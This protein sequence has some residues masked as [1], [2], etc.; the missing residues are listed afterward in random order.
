MNIRFGHQCVHGMQVPPRLRDKIESLKCTNVVSHATCV[1][2]R[3]SQHARIYGSTPT[4]H[5]QNSNVKTALS[6][7]KFGSS[8]KHSR[9]NTV[10]AHKNY[11]KILV[12]HSSNT[13][14]AGKH[15]PA[16]ALA[17]TFRFSRW[18]RKAAGQKH[19]WHTAMSAPNMVISGKLTCTLPPSVKEHWSSSYSAKFPGISITTKGPCT[20]EMYMSGSFIIPGVTTVASLNIALAA[21]DSAMHGDDGG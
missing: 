10:P 18:V 21:I 1:P 2:A 12:F 11:G 19:V 8:S 4:V 17:N 3:R 5:M 14:R 16:D 20:P 9:I 7:S 6:I 13:I 15:T